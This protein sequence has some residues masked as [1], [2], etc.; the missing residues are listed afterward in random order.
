MDGLDG[1]FHVEIG[2]DLERCGEGEGLGLEVLIDLGLNVVE[3]LAGVGEPLIDAASF[4]CTNG[5]PALVGPAVTPNFS[6]SVGRARMVGAV[7]DQDH[8]DGTVELGVGGLGGELSVLRGG[9]A[10]EDALGVRFL[11]LVAQRRGR[12]CL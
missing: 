2:I 6:S 1:A 3:R 12:S 4:T 11:R 7:V 5:M 8:A 9:L 10:F